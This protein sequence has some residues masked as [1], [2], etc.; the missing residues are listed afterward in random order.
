MAEQDEPKSALVKASVIEAKGQVSNAIPMTEDDARIF[1]SYGAILPPYDP[2]Q[3]SAMFERSTALRPNIDVYKTNIEGFGHR[4]EPTVKLD[5]EDIDAQIRSALMQEKL[6]DNDHTPDVPDTEVAAAKLTLETQMQFEKMRVEQ[7]FS[8]AGGDI[9]F[10]ELRERTRLDLEVTGNAYWEVLR[11]NL[12]E[13]SQIVLLPS[14]SVRLMRADLRFTEVEERRKVSPFA[15]RRFQAFRRLRHFVQVLYGQFVAYFKELD[16][17][18]ITSSKT[19]RVYDT[20]ADLKQAEPKV[21]PA[22]EVIH[23]KIHSTLSAYGVPRW[24]GATLSVLGSRAAEEVNV[25]YFDNKAV[26]PMAILVSGGSL[27][28][29]AADRITNYI[30]D[31]I[32]GKDNFHKILVL[33]A[34]AGGGS[35]AGQNGSRV[36]IEM[37]SMMD[38]QQ[39]DALFQQYDSNNI[40]KVGSQ[41]RTPKIL[42]GDMKDFNR[43]T[44]EAALEYA[45]QQI[46]QPERNKMDHVINRRILSLL[47]IRFYEFVSNAVA[48]K[49][50]PQLAEMIRE[51]VKA[52]IFTPAQGLEL[53]SDVFG[54]TFP[55]SDAPWLQKPIAITVEEIKAEAVAER[56][57]AAGGAAPPAAPPKKNLVDE[58]RHLLQLRQALVEVE[59]Q[60]GTSA[61]N[62]SRREDAE[63]VLKVPRAEF[64]AWFTPTAAE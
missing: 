30:K 9:S 63:K 23:F 4:F 33:E 50:P 27:A 55:K 40:E 34:E 15:Y 16:D 10:V 56:A 22:T 58:A 29:G 47:N 1:M 37:K 7:F 52:G 45:E 51:H 17:P 32:K 31:N 57:A 8:Y 2:R 43:A 64:E 62:D 59:N 36:R 60:A 26:P 41:F 6:A 5:A 13:V 54:E 49:D 39:Q 48:T 53:S 12:G 20:L 35:L 3:L 61:L 25:T 24:V 11:N 38:A 28:K 44:A 46:F 21:P 42:R 19:G 18:R 14:V